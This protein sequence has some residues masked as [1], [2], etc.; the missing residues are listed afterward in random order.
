[1]NSKLLYTMMKYAILLV[2]P[3]Q[4]YGQKDDSVS[5]TREFMQV[6]NVYKQLPL[7]LDI[8]MHNK[9]N[10]IVDE[11]D[12]SY[13]RASFYIQSN[14]SYIH[15]GEVEQ[16]VNDSLA[17]LVSDRLQQMV[18][19]LNGQS[20]L[21]RMKAMTGVPLQDSAVA[22]IVQKYKVEKTNKDG[23]M[24]IEL[25]DKTLL[26]TTSMPK[27]SIKVEYNP[28][29]KI[30]VRVTTLRRVLLPLQEADYQVLAADPVM[31]DKLLILENN[32]FYVIKEQSAEYVY[33]E[34]NH[35]S[36]VRTPVVMS[37]RI[38]KNGEGDF[39]PV[40]SYEAY[41]LITN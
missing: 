27:E 32:L 36:E 22:E 12:T 2:F 28:K 17:L 20:V 24:V 25:Q 33:K 26:Y 10:F 9:T 41:R 39:E 34:I 38:V 21:E 3:F 8:E 4:V 35:D 29:T 31:K 6:C 13:V 19:S 40:K 37:D 14:V 23:V 5:I 18:L 7:R 1:M 30:P 15:F 16:L 11:Q